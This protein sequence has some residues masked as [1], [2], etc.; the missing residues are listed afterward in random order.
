[1]LFWISFSGVTNE[2]NRTVNFGGST[3]W[4]IATT[5]EPAGAG[6]AAPTAGDKTLAG[7]ATCDRSIL[8]AA[9]NKMKEKC[10]TVITSQ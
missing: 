7:T 10:Q 6:T 5:G 4:L 2:G 9:E 1:M 3:T 8:F